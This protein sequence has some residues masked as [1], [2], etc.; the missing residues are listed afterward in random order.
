MIQTIVI[1]AV[2]TCNLRCR[3]CYYINEQTKNYGKRISPKLVSELYRTYS[4]YAVGRVD[5]AT[6]SWHGGEPLLLGRKYFGELLEL[7][8]DFFPEGFIQNCVQTNG[9]LVDEEW[10][11]FFEKYHVDIG[12]SLDLDASQH[13][14]N[15]PTASGGG[16]YV[17]VKE[18]IRLIQKRGRD[19]G[20]LAVVT[21][22]VDGEVALQNLENLGVHS[23]DVLL[24]MSNHALR[25][26]QGERADQ[27]ATAVC[28]SLRSLFE[29]WVQR[30]D[31]DVRIRLFEALISNALGVISDFPY[32]GPRAQ[33]MAQLVIVE[34][35]GELC[36]EP[37][38]GEIDRFKH[39]HEYQL[40]LNVASPNFTFTRAQNVL[41]ARIDDRG[42]SS[43]PR[44]C[45]FCSV[46]A[47]CRGSHPGSRF[48]DRDQSFDH[49][50]VHCQT[51]HRL[52]TDTAALLG[53]NG[54][55]HELPDISSGQFA[56]ENN[57]TYAING[58]SLGDAR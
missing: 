55:L 13:D 24:P 25:R 43:L 35:D 27:E 34:T 10:L 49:K 46:K 57:P 7:Q 5:H 20:V 16:S 19:V 51:M 52:C 58:N 39:G 45:E 23:F 30:D 42:F 56:E 54:L 29:A 32:T 15:R 36:L 53:A 9:T 2:R 33:S 50:S 44:E 3:Y 41:K 21:E 14:K 22:D 47:I 11:D 28:R 37:E 40:G 31:P 8:R 6:F 4:E 48:D 1:E 12:I 18:A 17:Q 26:L 38:F